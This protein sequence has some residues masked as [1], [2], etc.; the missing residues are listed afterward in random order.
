M[1]LRI[2]HRLEAGCR[3]ES[4]IFFLKFIEEI[5]D[6]IN[7][8]PRGKRFNAQNEPQLKFLYC[9]NVKFYIYKKII[10]FFFF[11]RYFR[12]DWT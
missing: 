11:H 3:S 5:K 1:Y 12:V 7:L 10:R 4:Y 2:G 8:L 9:V 6:L